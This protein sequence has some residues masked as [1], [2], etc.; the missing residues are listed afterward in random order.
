VQSQYVLQYESLE[1]D[2]WWWIARREIIVSIL[3]KLSAPLQERARL[4]DVGC[5]TGM[6]LKALREF[7]ATGVE[8]N[9]LL[10]ERAR[11]NTGAPILNEGLPLKG[12]TNSDFDF[13]LLL[14][15]LEHL[16]D[17]LGGLQ[18]AIAS[19]KPGGFVIINVPA[20]SWLWT[21]HDEVNEHKRR[22][23]RKQLHQLLHSAQ[24]QICQIQFWGSLLVPAAL[25]RG[26]NSK[27][28]DDYHVSIPG[29]PVAQILRTVLKFDYVLNKY[30]PSFTGLSLLA[31]ARK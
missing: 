10:A 27:S 31:V 16:E 25:L 8:P 4:L 19:L 29:P 22:Y 18:S 7:D 15:V 20:H 17:D 9:P 3:K 13:I 28:A 14:D 24:L 30:L 2:H 5:G 11:R 21:R 23:T 12:F 26:K 1:R 6:Q